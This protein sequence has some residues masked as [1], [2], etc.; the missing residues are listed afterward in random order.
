MGAASIQVPLVVG[1]PNAGVARRV[2]DEGPE[3]Q[4]PPRPFVVVPTAATRA[5]V[6]PVGQNLPAPVQITGSS[7]VKSLHVSDGV[8][9]WLARMSIE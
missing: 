5:A 1:W 8:P 6:L 2:S 9:Q 4:L 3:R 7:P